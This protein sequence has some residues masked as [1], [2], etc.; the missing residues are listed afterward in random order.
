MKMGKCKE[1]ETKEFAD[2]VL[3]CCFSGWIGYRE[4]DIRWVPK[5]ILFL[6]QKMGEKG[7]DENM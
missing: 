1:G 4:K 2:L 6:Q 7:T 3:G 5:F